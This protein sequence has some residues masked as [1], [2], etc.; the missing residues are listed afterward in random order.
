MIIPGF[1][2]RPGVHCGS[3]AVG[4]VLR[5][6]GVEVSEAMAFGLG[7]GLGFRYVEAPGSSPSRVF[8]GRSVRLEWTV[9]EVLGLDVRE[10]TEE[11]P[12][13][14]WDEV[15]AA[16]DRGVAPILSVELSALPY[17]RSA[18]PFGGHRV[19]LAG[20]D[21]SRSVAFLAD[22]GFPGLQEVPLDVLARAR[23]RGGLPLGAP[24]NRWIEL[25]RERPPLPLPAAIGTA[26]ERQAREMLSPAEETSG[27]AALE[28]FAAALPGWPAATRDPDDLRR[29]LWSGYQ[30]IERRG[31][32]GGLFRALYA[33]FLGEAEDVTPSLAPRGL[34]PAIRGIAA[35]WSEIADGLRRA[36]RAHATEVP[37][38][39]V[40]CVA[41]VA[42]SERQFFECLARV[43]DGDG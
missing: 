12:D 37:R 30:M 32:G 42:A 20:Y 38:A 36:V 16:V 1:E 35:A 34:R 41:R 33:R 9:G 23:S 29:C 15:R 6:A 27:L 21:A 8:H 13:R 17:W 31:T 19:V 14:A 43:G 39:V 40:A 25:S 5:L 26:L 10:R 3:T 22:T 7:A 11:V 18:T 28:G 4:D 2:H 24:G